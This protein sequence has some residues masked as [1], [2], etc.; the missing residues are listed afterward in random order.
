[1]DSFCPTC[2]GLLEPTDGG[3]SSAE[4]RCPYC[5]TSVCT[6]PDETRPLDTSVDGSP[7]TATVVVGG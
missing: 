7:V 6:D 5:A 3:G 1:M 4:L 2:G